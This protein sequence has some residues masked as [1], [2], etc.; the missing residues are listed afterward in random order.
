MEA[1]QWVVSLAMDNPQMGY[2]KIAVLCRRYETPVSNRMACRIMKAWGLLRKKVRC[3]LPEIY[4]AAK[5]YELLP[6]RP[7]EVWQTDV[8]YLHI[9]NHG[10]WYAVTVI[11]YYSR[12]LL[13]AHFTDRC[14]AQEALV[15]LGL[16][17]AEAE[18]IHGLLGKPPFLVTDNGSC[19]VARRFVAALDGRF[20]QVRIRYRTP[21]QLGLLE[22]FHRTLKE[23]EIYW[24]LPE[25][26]AEA[27]RNLADYGRRYNG[28]RPHWGLIPVE[29]GDPLVPGDVYGGGRQIALPKWQKWAKDA[30]ERLDRLMAEEA[31]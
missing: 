23:E 24:R 11:D 25:N 2:K 30:K 29:G 13:A 4:Q 31:A 18:R 10:W 28:Y 6:Q 7:N 19:F 16:A 9:P 15:A 3:R 20:S 8:T 1:V 12:Y 17:Q 26:P 22:R 27:R 21:T 5:L 14:T